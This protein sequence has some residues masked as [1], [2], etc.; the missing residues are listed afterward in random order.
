MVKLYTSLNLKRSLRKVAM[1]KRTI[2]A[3]FQIVFC[4]I[5]SRGKC[6]LSNQEK[7]GI[8]KKLVHPSLTSHLGT[9]NNLNLV[10]T[11]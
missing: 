11:Y 4:W 10:D 6:A 9:H 5:I 3:I 8:F 1:L 2:F 7:F